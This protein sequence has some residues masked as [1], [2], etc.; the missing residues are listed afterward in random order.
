[1]KKKRPYKPRKTV[2]KHTR[3]SMT[4]KRRRKPKEN[5]SIQFITR[6]LR[7]LILFVISA[8]IIYQL[9]KSEKK[10]ES[11]NQQTVDESAQ[12]VV[13]SSEQTNIIEEETP[14]IE[15][16]PLSDKLNY[17]INKILFSPLLA[18]S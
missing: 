6:A 12:T 17:S 1:M 13:D 7:L 11:G 10:S 15:S 14:N 18:Q 3:S 5:K 8:F 16:M 2:S 9:F 4:V